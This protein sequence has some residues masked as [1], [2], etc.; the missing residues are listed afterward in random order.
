MARVSTVRARGRE[1]I[2]EK[3]VPPGT[4]MYVRREHQKIYLTTVQETANSSAGTTFSTFT[5]VTS[6]RRRARKLLSL[7]HTHG[8]APRGPYIS[9]S[10]NFG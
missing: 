9:A 6:A 7:C 1:P 4:S 2:F 8:S 10:P 3:R 5:A